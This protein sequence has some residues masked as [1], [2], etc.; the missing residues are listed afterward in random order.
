M[1]EGCYE[2]YGRPTIVTD[3]TL[4]AAELIRQVYEY[5]IVGGNLHIVVDDWNLEDDD[6][7]FC[8]K[9]IAKGGRS[10]PNYSDEC[11]SKEQ[12]VIEERCCKLLANMSLEE[13]VSALALHDGYLKATSII[14]A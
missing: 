11:D 4:A 14:N 13:R 3:R 2:D 12:L 10:D 9:E 5:S 7:E 1:C 8:L 6:L